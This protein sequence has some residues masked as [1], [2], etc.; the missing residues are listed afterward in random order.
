MGLSSKTR[1]KLSENGTVHGEDVILGVMVMFRRLPPSP[2][3][4]ERASQ[5]R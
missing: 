1:K 5:D 3:E 4:S 2:E